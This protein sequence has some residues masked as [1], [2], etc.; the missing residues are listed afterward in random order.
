M[1]SAI[2]FAVGLGNIWRFPFRAY[3]NGGGQQ[4]FGLTSHRLRLN[5]SSKSKTNKLAPYG[6]DGRLLLTANFKRHVT[7]KL[8]QK[9]KFRL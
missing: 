9:S 2:G 4:L 5:K 3:R 7:Q 1:L 8:G 6:T